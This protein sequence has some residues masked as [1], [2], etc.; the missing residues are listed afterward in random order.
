[1]GS[2]A[3]MEILLTAKNV[4]DAAFA[5]VKS[6]CK[7]LTSSVFSLNTAMGT[8]AGVAGMGAIAK[9]SMD[10]TA[11]MQKN[12]TMAGVSTE[13]YQELTY[14]AGQYM[15]SQDALTD[16]LKELSLRTDEYV[17][18]AGGSAKESF[19]RLGFTQADLNKRLKD[20]PGLLREVIKRMEDLDTA[21]Q[22]RI[23]DELF[24]GTGGE[25]FVGMI[26]A[27]TRS[28]DKFRKEAQALGVVMDQDL[29][30][31]STRA[32]QEIDS[33]T[34]VMKARFQVVVADLA[35]D[36][37]DLAGTMSDWM[38]ENDDLIKQN[39]PKYFRSVA[40]SLK[41]VGSAM[42]WVYDK[43]TVMNDAFAFSDTTSQIASIESRLASLQ[44]INKEENTHNKLIENKNKAMAE[45]IA[46]VRQNGGLQP[47]KT[48]TPLG[49]GNV[50][51]SNLG[52]ISTEIEI[53]ALTKKLK[54]LKEVER[55][56]LRAY[57]E[58]VNRSYLKSLVSFEPD[59]PTPSPMP[60]PVDKESEASW[61]RM[62]KAYMQTWAEEQA[63]GW[64]EYQ[65]GLND[66]KIALE[67]FNT[68]YKQATMSTFDFERDQLKGKLSLYDEY[69]TDKK[70]L[71]EWFSAEMVDIGKREAGDVTDNLEVIKNA[72]T[73]VFASMEEQWVSFCTGGAVSF[74]D[75]AKSVVAD[76]ARITFQENVTQPMAG[77]VSTFVGGLFNANGN[78]FDQSGVQ[79]YAQ[80][81][82]FTNQI[83]SE[84][85]MFAHGGGFGVMGEDGPEAIVPLKRM[86]SGNMG[87]EFQGAQTQGQQVINHYHI[88]VNALDAS[89]VQALLLEHAETIGAAVVMDYKNDGVSRSGL[90]G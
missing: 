14:A 12:A 34:S 83:V 48:T 57:T 21:A 88:T 24:G 26:D 35:P 43:A 46:T 2:D 81:G 70:A 71:E 44:G 22:I 58:K 51:H 40:S 28:L 31:N 6:Q 79:A 62:Q 53:E 56:E 3:K 33:L 45:Y 90:N 5:S 13:A 77:V 50:D 55:V 20:T 8:L 1:M 54:T 72:T 38:Q 10:A 16:G 49:Y 61:L 18:T 7:E 64:G 17:Q 82:A 63:Q 41:S 4:T 47:V 37:A 59:N 89:S 60:E 15:I 30:R 52:K 66:R 73:D 76:I 69:V 11:E 86:P 65:Q 32:K 78:A 27:G 87:V 19:E 23:A 68:D 84:P 67:E 25:Q 39:L 85:T 29:I 9:V 75:F 80:G 36:I 42:G 74:S